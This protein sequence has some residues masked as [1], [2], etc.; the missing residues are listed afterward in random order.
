MVLRL[1][2]IQFSAFSPSCFD[3][4]GWNFVCDFAFIDLR[5]C[6]SFVNLRQFLLQ[7]CPFVTQITRNTVFRTFLLYALTNSDEMC[8]AFSL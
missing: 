8:M 7:L 5:S 4:L 3:T 6:L 2:E 1:L